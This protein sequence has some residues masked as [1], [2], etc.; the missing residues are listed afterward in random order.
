M[1]KII[2]LI[3]VVLMVASVA[4]AAGKI[5]IAPDKLG[6]LKGTW[7]GTLTFSVGNTCVAKLEILNDT[8]PIK[9]VITL[10]NLQDQIAQMLAVTGGTSS[11]SNDEGKIT[12]QGSIMW[13]GPKNFFEFS[14]TGDKKGEGWFYFNGARGD[15]TLTKKK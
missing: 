11:V 9:G 6:A 12:T 4:L 10:V 7:E 2:C 14:Q 13:A 1:K 5:K 15:V 3:A 8:V